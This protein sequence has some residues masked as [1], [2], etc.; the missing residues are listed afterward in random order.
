MSITA[1]D[2]NTGSTDAAGDVVLGRPWRGLVLHE[3][4]RAGDALTLFGGSE[5]LSA[6]QITGDNGNTLTVYMDRWGGSAANYIV[7]PEMVFTWPDD[8]GDSG[9]GRL[10][11]MTQPGSDGGIPCSN[12][13]PGVVPDVPRTSI[14]VCLVD[15]GDKTQFEIDTVPEPATVWLVGACAVTLLLCTRIRRLGRRIRRRTSG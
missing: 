1:Q 14:A 11:S 9:A 12:G 7:A 4:D 15:C 2:I 8:W 13:C 5:Y 3:N 6:G 10:Q